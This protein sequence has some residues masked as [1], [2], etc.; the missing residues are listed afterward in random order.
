MNSFGAIIVPAALRNQL[1]ADQVNPGCGKFTRA[2]RELAQHVP[3]THPGFVND[4]DT[5]AAFEG[6]EQMGSQRSMT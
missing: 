3:M 2:H 4:I 1:L 6:F 5:P